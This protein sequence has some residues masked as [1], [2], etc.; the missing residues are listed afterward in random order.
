MS[1]TFLADP[2]TMLREG[3]LL[4]TQF[5]FAKDVGITIWRVFGGFML[6]AVIGVPLGIA[7][8]AYKPVEAFFEPFVSFA[9]YLP[10]VGVHSAADPVGRASAR[11]RSSSSSSS[12]RSSRS[13]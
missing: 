4:F 1:K 2:L 13:C 10:G 6:A 11:C 8:G 9:R 3:W 7:M 5:G 12:A